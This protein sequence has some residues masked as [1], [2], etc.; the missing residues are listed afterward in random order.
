MQKTIVVRKK[1]LSLMVFDLI[2][3]MLI[4]LNAKLGFMLDG[5]MCEPVIWGILNILK[6][7]YVIC[8]FE[9]LNRDKNLSKLSI[10]DMFVIS[11]EIFCFIIN[12]IHIIEFGYLY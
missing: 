3:L 1:G 2:H 9:K 6:V 8:F 11:M 4:S 5:L 7:V 10:L 12:L